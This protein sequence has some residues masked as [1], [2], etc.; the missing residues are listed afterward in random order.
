MKKVKFNSKLSLN[1]ETVANLN[2]SELNNVKGG[3]T[4]GVTV[5]WAICDTKADCPT[6]SPCNPTNALWTCTCDTLKQCQ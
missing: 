5:C 4:N 3:E 6:N 2:N 1:K